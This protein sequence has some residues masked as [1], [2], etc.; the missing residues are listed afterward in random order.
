MKA[1][2]TRGTACL[3][4]TPATPAASPDVA[5]AANAVSSTRT[6]ITMPSRTHAPAITIASTTTHFTVISMH[7]LVLVALYPI[8]RP[9]IARREGRPSWVQEALT[10]HRPMPHPGGKRPRRTNRRPPGDWGEPGAEP[11]DCGQRPTGC[12]RQPAACL[13]IKS[14]PLPGGRCWFRRDKPRS[15]RCRRP[16]WAAI[17]EV[18]PPCP[19]PRSLAP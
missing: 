7:L 11:G 18:P 8:A 15:S 19:T 12:H 10:A 1:T 16:S 6:H 3:M 14:G 17:A 9:T 5:S 4:S 2:A 13:E